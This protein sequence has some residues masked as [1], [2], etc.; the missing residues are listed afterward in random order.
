MEFVS[1]Y[2][3]YEERRRTWRRLDVMLLITP[4]IFPFRGMRMAAI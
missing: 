1:G 2:D 3:E 4:A